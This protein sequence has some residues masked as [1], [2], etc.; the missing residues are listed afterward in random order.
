[1]HTSSNITYWVSG[2]GGGGGGGRGGGSG[3]WSDFCLSVCVTDF[4]EL[5]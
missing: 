5:Q 3:C 4:L 1:M 2:A